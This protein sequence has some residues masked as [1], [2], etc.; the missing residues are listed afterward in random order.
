[1]LQD[2]IPSLKMANDDSSSIF[3]SDR[4]SQQ[5]SREQVNLL[6][7][8][9]ID[10]SFKCFPKHFSRKR[11]TIFYTV[12]INTVAINRKRRIVK[13]MQIL[14]HQNWGSTQLKVGPIHKSCGSFCNQ[15]I[16]CY[17]FNK[18]A[19]ANAKPNGLIIEY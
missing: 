16:Y 8:E 19:A 4:S 11:R 5:L 7:Y 13:S 9:K 1:M 15:T 2:N 12:F 14:L 18:N 17:C 10:P 6:L 3:A